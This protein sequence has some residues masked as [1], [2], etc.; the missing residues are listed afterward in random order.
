M[1]L[2]IIIG[3]FYFLIWIF[4]LKAM[5]K[6]YDELISPIFWFIIGMVFII[7]F[8]LTSKNKKWLLIYITSIVVLLIFMLVL[9]YNPNLYQNILQ[10]FN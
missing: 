3:T 8:G 10:T 4:S 5:H 6:K 7:L 1:I 2:K 9:Y